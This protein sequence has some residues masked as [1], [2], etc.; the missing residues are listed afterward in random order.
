MPF[1]TIS[2]DPRSRRWGFNFQRIVRRDREISRWSTPSQ[3][4]EIQS[5]ADAGVLDGI[6]DITQGLGLDVRP[7]AKGVY[8][9]RDGEDT[10]SGTGGVDLRYRLTPDL[11]LTLTFNTDFAETE[12]DERRVNLTRFPLFFPEKRPFFLQDAGIFKFGG[13]RY[14]PLPYFSRRIGLDDNGR[15]VRIL[16]GAKLTGRPADWNLGFLGTY[17]ESTPT[18]DRKL[19]GVA[20]VSRNVLEESTVGLI[21]TAG[22]PLTN[23]DNQVVGPD[24]NY[25]TSTLFGNRVLQANA[26]FLYSNTTGAGTPVTGEDMTWGFKLDYPNDRVNWSVDVTEIGANFNAALGFVPRRAIREYIGSWRYRWRPR[27]T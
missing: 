25:R 6:G 21:A 8:E 13:I 1:Q 4:I 2:F 11:T 9:H 12:V 5:V 22:D 14:N 3:N 23:G 24:F 20:R 18:V 27:D 15:P 16:A 17:M 10:L 26:F 7:Y 19:V